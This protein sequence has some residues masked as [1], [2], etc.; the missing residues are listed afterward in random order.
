[1]ITFSL[2]GTSGILC[3]SGNDMPIAVFPTK[4]AKTNAKLTLLQNPEEFPTD[5]IISWPGEYEID[6]ISLR[7]IGHEEG[8][9]VSFAMEMDDARCG[10]LSTPV[11]EWTDH[12][13]ELL[14]DV[15]VLSIPAEKTKVAQKLIEQIDPRVLIPILSENKEDYDELL[16]VFGAQGQ[17]VEKEFK[18]KGLPAEGRVVVVLG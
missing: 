17:E 4:G 12:E 7:G 2:I 8:A 11:L 14:G 6:G 3:D 13:L 15:D 5:G 18:L 1:M 10:F 16:K 9:R